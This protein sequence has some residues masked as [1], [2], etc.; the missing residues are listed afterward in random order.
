MGAFL[1]S[2]EEVSEKKN[3]SFQDYQFKEKL[4]KG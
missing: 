1:G 2:A 4:E 3:A